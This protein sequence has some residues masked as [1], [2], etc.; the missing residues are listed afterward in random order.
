M[1]VA[2]GNQVFNMKK[3]YSQ[4]WLSFAIPKNLG[5]KVAKLVFLPPNVTPLSDYKKA[6]QDAGY[7]ADVV[8]DMIDG[9]ANSP[10]YEGKTS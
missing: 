3:S 5:M 7:P 2:A 6:L 1:N 8:K 10:F 9:L 4:K